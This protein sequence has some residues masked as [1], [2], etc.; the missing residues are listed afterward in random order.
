MTVFSKFLI[1]L[2]IC[3]S[4][5][6]NSHILLSRNNKSVVI[7]LSSSPAGTNVLNT[8]D[9]ISLRKP[10]DSTNV[11]FNSQSTNDSSNLRMFSLEEC[12]QLALKNNRI[13]KRYQLSGK[14][15]RINLKQ[16]EYR[17]LPSG[18]VSGGRDENRNDDLGYLIVKK[19]VSSN[20]GLSRS[21]ETGG[22]VSVGVSNS[23]SESSNNTGVTNFNT[24]VGISISQPLLRG[25][26]LEYNQIPIRRAKAYANVSLLSINQSMINLITVIERQYWDL[27]LVYEDLKI[28]NAAL[29]RAMELLEVNKSLIEAGR[30]AS[31]EIVQAE[32]DVATREIS[33]AN[34]ENSIISAQIALQAQLDLPYRFTIQP[35]TEMTFQPIEVNAAECLKNAYK[36]RPDWLIHEKYFK[37]EK[38]NLRLAQNRTR[39]QLGSY[40]GISSNSTSTQSL[41]STFKE[42]FQFNSLTWNIGLSFVFPF[43][44]QVLMNGYLLQQ[45]SHDRQAIYMAE[46]KDN[47]RI[48]VENAVRH[49]Q[50]SLNQVKLAQRAKKL[51]DKKL[52]LEE[53]KMKVG[54]STNFQ[55]IAYQRDLTNAQNSELRAIATY[56]KA[57]GSLEQTMGTTLLK[58]KIELAE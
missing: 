1:L 15:A 46:L 14:S 25:A 35:T 29:Q 19:T 57:L 33:V 6:L 30:M 38:M 21:L 17:Y 13:L 16:A 34:A 45:L 31:Q 3:L 12:I 5:L 10:G 39:Y 20:I 32:S 8:Q 22:A 36:F 9:T 18:Y 58:W 41:G 48:A 26:G 27:I 24:G 44:K 28:Q 2:L 51:S 23:I 52:I 55:V 43:N 40:G 47:I 56:L 42:A 49:V 37:I 4:F 54:R 7:E 53:E 11:V 50:Y